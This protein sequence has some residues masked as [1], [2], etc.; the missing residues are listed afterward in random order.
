MSL[1]PETQVRCVCYF[2]EV[3]SWSW[4]SDRLENQIPEV[5]NGGEYDKSEF[6]TFCSAKWIR[7]MRTVPGKTRQNG[8][9]ERMNRILNERARSMRIYSGLPKTFWADAVT[10]TAYLINK[11]PSVPLKFKLPKKYGQEKN[12]STLTWELLVVLH[13]FTSIQ[14]K[15]TSYAKAVKRYF[16]GYGLDI[17][18]LRHFR[19]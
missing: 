3:E 2:Q 5:H 10:T 13:M 15:E 17:F 9:A 12:S 14:R 16:I 4:K 8:V 7:L 6:K 11:G 1:F 18:G 19:V